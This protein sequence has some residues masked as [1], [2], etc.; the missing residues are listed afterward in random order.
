M[1]KRNQPKYHF[2]ANFA[3]ARTGL[4]EI[5]ANEKSFRLEVYIFSMLS[6]SLF[7]FKFEAL[8]TLF[9]VAA[10]VLV[11]V[12]ECINSAIE[13]TVDLVTTEYHPLAKTAKDAASA[14]VM[15]GNFFVGFV[16]IAAII[17]KF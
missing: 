15:I 14:A 17:T 13:R 4:A 9:I 1:G 8:Y 3:Y 5:W 7:W 16:W 12:I 6:L 10:Q 11:L 2:F